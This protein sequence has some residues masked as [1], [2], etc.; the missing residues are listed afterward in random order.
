MVSARIRW[1]RLSRYALLIVFAGLLFLYV[2]PARS[3]INTLRESHQ[4]AA[5][6]TKLEREHKALLAR[7]LALV[8]PKVIEVEARSLGMVRPGERPFVVRNLPSGR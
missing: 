6:V 4:R 2:N 7:K 5:Q 8:D 3:Y 1:D